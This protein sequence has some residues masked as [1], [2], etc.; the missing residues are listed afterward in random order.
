M[1]NALIG[2]ILLLLGGPGNPP[3]EDDFYP[4]ATLPLPDGLAL[5]VS[6]ITILPGGR[7]MVCTRR[8]EVWIVENAYAADPSTAR[9]KRFAEGLQ[10][11]LGL[12]AHEGWIWFVQRGELSR[13]RDVDGDDRVDEV[14]TVCDQWRISGNYHEYNFGPRLGGDGKLWI[15]TNKPFGGEPF[16]RV[17]W[18]GFAIRIDPKT[19]KMD[20][21]AC[22]LRSPA[23]VQNAPWGDLFYTDNQGEWCG[24]SKLSH[25]AAGDFHGHPHGI[26]SC[27]DGL[28]THPQ[29]KNP[30]NGMK[31]PDVAK[32]MPTFKLPAV[33]FPYD[34]MG[35]S[36]AGFVWDS[37]DGKFGPFGGQ[38]FV[39]DQHHAWVMRVSLEQVHGH[40]QGACYPFRRGLQCGAIRVAWGKDQ[41]VLFVGQTQRGWGSRGS[42]P[43]GLQRIAWTGKVPFEVHTMSARKNGFHLRFTKP[44]DPKTAGDPA[45]YTMESYTYLLHS[46][47]GSKEVDKQKPSIVAASVSADRK[48]VD[49]KVEGLRAGYVHELH[50]AGVRSPEGFPLLHPHAYYTLINIP[51]GACAQPPREMEQK[52]AAPG[53]DQE[54]FVSLFDGKTTKGW[55]NPFEWGKVAVVDGEI[56]LT[57]K[58]KFFLVTE[59]TYRD[60]VLDVDVNVPDGGNSG[61]QFRCHYK[62]NKLWGYQAE[63]DTSE[64]AWAGGL[65]DEGRRGWLAPLKG[66]PKL[67]AAYKHG[68]WNHY[69]VHAEGGRLRIWVNGVLTTDWFDVTDLE[70]HLALQHHGE[71]GLT[72]RFRN[73]RIRELGGH[74]WKKLFDGK[75]LKGWHTTPGGSWKVEDG[76]IVGTSPKEER[77]H[78][79]L[80]TDETFGDFAARCRFRVH[81][82]D[83]GFYFRIAKAKGAVSARGFQVEID[84]SKETGGLYETG[85]RAWVVKPPAKAVAQYDPKKWNQLELLAHEGRVVVKINGQVTADLAAD[86]GRREG[87]IALQLHGGQPM[88]V[89]YKDVEVLTRQ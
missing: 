84:T 73:V 16:G 52:P 18:R 40:W 7:P 70:G 19:G 35:K 74:G 61:V 43:Y 54:E 3:T 77:R 24:A 55:M 1:T 88:H 23:G 71:K 36:P 42:K 49:L 17:T 59:K 51:D 65:Y 85:G 5:E 80:V 81:E 39:S 86:P 69:R 15:T 47:Y 58:R 41:N 4:L 12:L 57:G 87:H 63:V 38:V 67:Q 34:K 8:G 79:L 2:F 10:E 28:W 14:E 82:G 53:K 21:V 76:V 50:L 27:K 44:V 22:G 56:R 26:F 32:Q 45:S 64:R 9:F 20:P 6:G 13:M 37:T 66:K 72:Y 68:T 33:W 48:S 62:R 11:P 30:P 29:P 31:M 78:G 75:T 83:S 60:F 25:V 46:S 89:E